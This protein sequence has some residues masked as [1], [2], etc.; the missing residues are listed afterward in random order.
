MK[1]MTTKINTESYERG[2]TLKFKDSDNYIIYMKQVKPYSLPFP[3]GI[4]VMQ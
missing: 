2:D 3:P 1:N 4:I